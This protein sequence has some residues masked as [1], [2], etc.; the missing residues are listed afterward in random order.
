MVCAVRI[1]V[2]EREGVELGAAEMEPQAYRLGSQPGQVRPG[3]PRYR[4]SQV[5]SADGEGSDN[6]AAGGI[7]DLDCDGSAGK[8]GSI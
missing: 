7:Q 5:I 4:M 8:R 1:T 2:S 6:R 3:G